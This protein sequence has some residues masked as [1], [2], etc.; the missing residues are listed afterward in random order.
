MRAPHSRPHTAVARPLTDRATPSSSRLGADGSE[1]VGCMSCG[2]RAVV[3]YELRV[4]RPLH[5]RVPLV[6]WAKGST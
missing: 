6:K 2:L 4:A 5:K 3:S 1:S